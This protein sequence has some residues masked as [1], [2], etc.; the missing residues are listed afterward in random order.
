MNVVFTERAILKDVL[1]KEISVIGGPSMGH[2][3]YTRA[4]S[5]EISEAGV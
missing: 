1:M 3:I 2:E 4:S 5:R